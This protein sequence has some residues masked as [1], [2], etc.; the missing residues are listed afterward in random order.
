LEPKVQPA[1]A[2]KWRV[3][4]IV[5]S[6]PCVLNVGFASPMLA[7]GTFQQ[8][9]RFM[10]Y[11]PT[12]NETET[13]VL[14]ILLDRSNIAGYDLMSM[15]GGKPANQLMAAVA[16]LRKNDLIQVVGNSSTEKDFQFSRF[17]VLP[18]ARGLADILARRA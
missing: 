9:G 2:R 4:A 14:Q 12:L 18:S 1:P 8:T 15:S 3:A 7:F 11:L 10:D 6:Q 13:Q 17:A 16:T 5:Q